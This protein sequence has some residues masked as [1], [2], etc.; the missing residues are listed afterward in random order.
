[1]FQFFK[2][3]YT[4]L[5]NYFE[6]AIT[7]NNLSNAIIFCGNDVFAQYY[8]AMALAK[9][10]NCEFDAKENCECLNCKW[11]KDNK[12]PEVITVSK[13]DNKNDD[14]KTVISLSQID[15]VKDNLVSKTQNQR[16][17]IFCDAD[18]EEKNAF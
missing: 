16:F 13:V 15:F 5:T 1:M 4:F 12:H 18:L 2:E 10:A 8:F 11:I 9:A 3:N 14:S 7:S 6:T 17:I